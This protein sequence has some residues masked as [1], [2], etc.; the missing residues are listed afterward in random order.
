VTTTV[1]EQRTTEA[2]DAGKSIVHHGK[3]GERKMLRLE[4][5]ELEILP[6]SLITPKKFAKQVIRRNQ[7]MLTAIREKKTDDFVGEVGCPHCQEAD[8][9]ESC[10]WMSVQTVLPLGTIRDICL[11]ARF[12]NVKYNQTLV[13]YSLHDEFFMTARPTKKTIAF[14][15]AHVLWAER[16]LDGTYKAFAK[17]YRIKAPRHVQWGE[18][19]DQKEWVLS[20]DSYDNLMAL[21][22]K[23]KEK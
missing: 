6:V 21:I 10:R 13:D 8:G 5:W 1:A 14:L 2:E 22:R 3:R 11:R 17:E 19:N 9:C 7:A 18:R 12:G 20:Q 15:E 23:K 16:I 4:G